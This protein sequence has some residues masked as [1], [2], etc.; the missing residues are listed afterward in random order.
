VASLTRIGV[1][2]KLIYLFLAEDRLLGHCTKASFFDRVFIVQE[3]A[4]GLSRYISQLTPEYITALAETVSNLQVDALRDAVAKHI[5]FSTS[6][7]V[8]LPV[9]HFLVY[10]A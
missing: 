4:N 9:C 3:D 6:I 5:S 7:R 10:G 1:L 2:C 8:H